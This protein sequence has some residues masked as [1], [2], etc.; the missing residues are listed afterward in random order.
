MVTQVVLM[1]LSG[2]I[3][4]LTLLGD[5]RI[6]VLYVIAALIAAASAFDGPARQALIPTLVPRN[7]LAPA[8]SMNILAFSISRM[9]GPAIGGFSVAAI[10]LAA[11]YFLDAI[12]FLFVL[13]ALVVL[14]TDSTP[15]A[16]RSGGVQAVVEG[17]QFIRSNPIIWGVMSLD[18]FATLL[19]STVGLAPVFA[20]DVLNVGAQGFGLLLS[21]PAAGAVIGGLLV[22]FV[23]QASRPGRIMILSVV[24]Y[25]AS[26]FLFGLSNSLLLAMVALAGAGAF[27]SVSMAMRAAVRNLAT[28]DELRGRVAA[29]N[30]ALATG[31]PRL[32]EF[33]SG[34]MAGVV[35][36]RW[37]M[38][39]GGGAVVLVSIAMAAI[40]PGMDRYRIDE[41]GEGQEHGA[42]GRPIEASSI[43]TGSDGVG[44]GQSEV[45]ARRR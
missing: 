17:L 31:G 20:E 40:V 26:L 10:G 42:D 30:S 41:D 32:G 37:A 15:I 36:A 19:G 34:M 12:S 5:I 3:G 1:L 11:T 39:L 9:V 38:M 44:Q 21:A 6:W 8:M 18:F 4:V 33:Q 22:S 13:W 28:P 14:E 23:P 24:G 35:G 7:Q 16:G 43:A 27:D 45:V 29:A 25:G 2:S